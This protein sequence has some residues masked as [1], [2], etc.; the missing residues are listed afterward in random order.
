MEKSGICFYWLNFY[1][2]IDAAQQDVTLTLNNY[3]A[4][5]AS[6]LNPQ[7]IYKYASNQNGFLFTVIPVSCTLSSY[8]LHL[9]HSFF[10]FTLLFLFLPSACISPLIRTVRWVA[11]SDLCLCAACGVDL[12]SSHMR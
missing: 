2:S 7:I 3:I 10:F 12:P 1:S 5:I 8:H 9:Y 6:K 4:S 11:G